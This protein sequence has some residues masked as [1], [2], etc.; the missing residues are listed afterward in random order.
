MHFFI[1]FGIGLFNFNELAIYFTTIGFLM[2]ISDLKNFSY[3]SVIYILLA[4]TIKY[5][6]ALPLIGAIV[7]ST[8]IFLIIDYKKEI[9]YLFL[10]YF[11]LLGYYFYL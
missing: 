2:A 3:L 9:L 7:I 1:P 11:F 4:L 8:V 10:K 6:V 5:S